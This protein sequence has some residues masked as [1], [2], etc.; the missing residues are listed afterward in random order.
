MSAKFMCGHSDGTLPGLDAAIS[1]HP[2]KACA[3]VKLPGISGQSACPGVTAHAGGIRPFYQD[4][5]VTLFH[6]DCRKIL[7][8]LGH[9]DV[10]ITDPP[11]SE[12]TQASV[13]SREMKPWD[14]SAGGAASSRVIDLGFEP[15]TDALRELAAV[16]I[17]RLTRRWA[18]VFSD[19]ESDYL[20]RAALTAAGLDYVR[21]GAW[22]R[23]NSAPQFSGDRPAAGFEA[24]TICHPRGRKRWNGGGKRAVWSVP[25]VS[26][27]G[28]NGVRT[29]P[30]Q[31]P[32]QLMRTLVDQFS[33]PGE[34]I[35]D[36][37]AGSGSTLLAA[38]FLGRRAIGIE[39]DE[40]FCRSAAQRLMNAQ[41]TIPGMTGSCQ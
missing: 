13:R 25:I 21:T 20:W 24:V 12:K 16:E 37:Y 6:G 30:A 34:T 38:A 31:K 26:N 5:F 18:L 22:I 35:L 33:E 11:Y 17:A 32:D 1:N 4:E 3:G 19:A 29:H 40:Q 28:H 2:W 39:R 41:L 27:R 10:T 7:P 9:V 15:L 36:P 8:T 23:E 14:R